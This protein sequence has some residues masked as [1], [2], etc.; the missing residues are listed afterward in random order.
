ME[1]VLSA[2]RPIPADGLPIMGPSREFSGLYVAVMHSGVTLGALA[3][4]LIAQEIICGTPVEIL[5]PYRLERF[6]RQ[7]N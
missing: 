6:D 3:G 4:R 5:E 1:T 2:V 7:R